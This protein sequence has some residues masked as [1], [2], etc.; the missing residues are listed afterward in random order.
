M[1]RLFDTP[2]T[3]RPPWSRRAERIAIVAFW[4]FLA[5]L[6]VARRMVNPFGQ[7]IGAAAYV[8]A[9]MYVVW[10]ALTPAI[11]S[12]AQRLPLERGAAA[13]RV[14]VLGAIGLAV[15]VAVELIQFFLMRMLVEPAALPGM[16]DMWRQIGPL[17]AIA[18][19]WF[20]DE[21][22]IY[23]AVLA[24]GFARNFFIHLR[25]RE[26]EAASLQAQLSEAR[27]S[28]LRMQLNPHFLFN[29]LHTVSSLAEDDPAGVQRIVA[30]LS[31]LLRRSL[32]GTK[33]QEVPLSEE[34]S[35]LRDYLEIQRVRFQGRLEVREHVEDA[36]LDALI[37]NLILQPIV[38]NAVKHGGEQSERAVRIAIR[39][40]IAEGTGRLAL[41]VRDNGPGLAA[42]AEER[43]ARAGRVG[44]AN[45]RARLEALY[46]A[47]ASLSLVD[48][49]GGG[50]EARIELPYHTASDIHTAAD[51]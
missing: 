28:A 42:G 51:A 16:A 44:I 46:G 47:D 7:T 10:A 43:A 25:E 45:T 38:E 37:P 49:E 9:M 11:F 33:R 13:K 36:A 5:A 1:M 19:M 50:L 17:D 8:G 15:A 23:L 22:V 34:L 30:R 20:M 6:E 14:A 39:A 3:G 35:F 2:L 41:S 4:A 12:L 27:L 48:A 21:F 18:R 32:E 26:Q 40:R 31:N 29:T 24:V